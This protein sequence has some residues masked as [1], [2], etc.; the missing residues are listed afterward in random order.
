MGPWRKPGTLEDSAGEFIF[1][2]RISTASGSERGSRKG[3]TPEVTLA[4][5]R[6]TDS[7]AESGSVRTQALSIVSVRFQLKTGMTPLEY[8]PLS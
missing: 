3:F 6:G 4:T 1:G 5:A 8:P 7:P 2:Q